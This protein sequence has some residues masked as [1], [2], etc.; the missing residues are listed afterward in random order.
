MGL[1]VSSGAVDWSELDWGESTLLVIWLCTLVPASK[2]EVPF[3][4]GTETNMR[5]DLAYLII[6][7]DSNHVLI[8]LLP[9]FQI[10]ILPRI[11]AF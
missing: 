7:V 8:S 4:L 11:P 9:P 5:T 1:P 10:Y 6:L 2:Y 3:G